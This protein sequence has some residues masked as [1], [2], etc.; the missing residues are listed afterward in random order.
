MIIS[1]TGIE[2]KKIL[3]YKGMGG[4]FVPGS[5]GPGNQPGMEPV[6]VGGVRAEQQFT[7]PGQ[8]SQVAFPVPEPGQVGAETRQQL[9]DQ[10]GH[11]AGRETPRQFVDPL[12]RGGFVAPGQ[13]IGGGQT[14][15][16]A[17]GGLEDTSTGRLGDDGGEHRQPVGHGRG[18]EGGTGTVPGGG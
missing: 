16:L 9:T 11:P 13:Q 17:Q 3:E 2:E 6:E 10:R 5:G 7:D 8:V 14:E 1:T 4:R 12:R 15:Q 18:V